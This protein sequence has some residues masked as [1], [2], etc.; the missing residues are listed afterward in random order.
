MSEGTNNSDEERVH[1]S[2]KPSN[3][4]PPDPHH[5]NPDPPSGGDS[6]CNLGMVAGIRAAFGARWPVYFEPSVPG[7]RRVM[8]CT[9]EHV[10]TCMMYRH[11][12]PTPLPPLH[13][14]HQTTR[15]IADSPQL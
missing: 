12:N 8:G 2:P 10:C 6:G 15:I 5:P 4:I 3:S 11:A 1:L 7:D 14:P 9:S 13:C